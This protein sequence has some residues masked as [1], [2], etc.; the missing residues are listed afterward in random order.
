MKIAKWL[1]AFVVFL[2]LTTTFVKH[3]EATMPRPTITMP[4]SNSTVPYADLE[5]IGT[6]SARA[7]VYL[8]LRDITAN[9][10]VF[11]RRE[12]DGSLG[13]TNWTLSISQGYLTPGREYRL[14]AF[15]KLDGLEVW[16][17]PSTHFFV[18]FPNPTFDEPTNGTSHN[19]DS[20]EVSGTNLSGGQMYIFVRNLTTDNL[21]ID[22]QFIPY[23]Q[24]S[25]SWA[26]TIPKN[27]LT[28]GHR[29]SVS[30]VSMHG[31]IVR[32]NHT[33]AW[34][35]QEKEFSIA[36]QQT[37]VRPAAAA[38][39]SLQPT[40]P[41]QAIISAQPVEFDRVRIMG[42]SAQVRGQV[43]H[44]VDDLYITIWDITYDNQ[45]ILETTLVENRDLNS[46][47]HVITELVRGHN[48]YAVVRSVIRNSDGS[49]F[50][51]E[52]ADVYFTIPV[53]PPIML[54]GTP[55]D[56]YNF[57]YYSE[58]LSGDGA[59]M[60]RTRIELID[61]GTMRSFYINWSVARNYH[62][63]WDPWSASDTQVARSLPGW[64]SWGHRPGLLRFPSGQLVAVGFHLHPHGA[65]FSGG[66]GLDGHMCMF[67]G[68]EGGGVLSN[69]EGGNRMALRAYNH[70]N[71]SRFIEA[72]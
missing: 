67:Y 57:A 35:Q 19:F 1:F 69:M 47:D 7:Q 46:F 14:T 55:L 8:S 13:Y 54:L 56:V 53:Q 66:N 49:I 26:F 9:S 61:L 5:I 28:P 22:N 12:V 63:D 65:S 33:E 24:N 30:I 59:F 16:T 71:I 44:G 60:D 6:N 29:Y 42:T 37:A 50:S 51:D 32:G 17:I 34:A 38:L 40:P 52:W 48:Y 18:D 21:V 2:G 15:A 58:G 11:D 62:T 45:V 68:R 43:P 41:R 36:H 25:S 4:G 72:E 31:Q 3:V 64:G 39:P 27:R 70:H 10:A 20:V 23:T